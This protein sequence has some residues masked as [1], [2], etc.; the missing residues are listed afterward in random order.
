MPG[1]TGVCLARPHC[2]DAAVEIRSFCATRGSE[3]RRPA[4][5]HRRSDSYRRALGPTAWA[6]PG[7]LTSDLSM[8]RR[9]TTHRAQTQSH[10]RR[11]RHPHRARS[12]RLCRS[13][14]ERHRPPRHHPLQP[15][16]RHQPAPSTSPTTTPG[17]IVVT[18]PVPTAVTTPVPTPVPAAA[19]PVAP[20]KVTYNKLTARQWSRSSKS[21]DKYIGKG[22]QVWGQ[23]TSSTQRPATATSWPTLPTRSRRIRTCTASPRSS[24]AMPHASRSTSRTMSS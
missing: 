11:D 5:E 17:A 16:R 20:A 13:G 24:P 4:T 9:E 7:A 10:H 1:P 23:S 15:L 3:S 19:K 6:E 14:V 18:T 21:P 8:Q 2:V 22:Y 12:R